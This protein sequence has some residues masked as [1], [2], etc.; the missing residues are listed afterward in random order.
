MRPN[1]SSAILAFLFMNEVFGM[2]LPWVA[3]V[4][5]H[6]PAVRHGA[7][8]RMLKHFDGSMSWHLASTAPFNC[9]VELCESGDRGFHVI[10]FPC[11]QTRAGWINSDLKVRLH[12]EPG[13]WRMWPDAE[14]PWL[15]AND[16]QGRTTFRPAEV[17]RNRQ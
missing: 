4:E 5:R 10:P 14:D 9:D 1:E 13:Q 17:E 15:H 11:R 3:A 7:L 8:G 6:F 12:I 16:N 2:K